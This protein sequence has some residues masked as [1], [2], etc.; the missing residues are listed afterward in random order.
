MKKPSKTKK[1]SVSS[2][3]RRVLMP[4]V[5]IGLAISLII[6][7]FLFQSLSTP[8]AP[9]MTARD[10]AIKEAREVADGYLEA[11]RV[12]DRAKVN[13]YRVNPIQD[14]NF[15]RC[16]PVVQSDL[17]ITSGTVKSYDKNYDEDINDTIEIIVF[18]PS[19]YKNGEPQ[20]N[21]NL[22]TM[23]RYPDSKNIWQIFN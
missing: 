12:C 4:L 22:L 18:S 2:V 1:S 16:N 3:N 11:L 21:S 19:I 9:D 6:G 5:I 20:G 17:R 13:S 7:L 15:N 8:K 10:I 23:V 14:Y